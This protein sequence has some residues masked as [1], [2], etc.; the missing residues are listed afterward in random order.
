MLNWHGL[1]A[2]TSGLVAVLATLAFTVNSA[3]AEQPAS[4]SAWYA[5]YVRDSELVRL[6]NGRSLNLYC[7]GSGSPTVI[8]E[9][10][11]GGS[12]YSWW[13]VQEKIAK[14]TRVC[15]YDRAGSGK[16]P[17]GPFPR[18]TRAQVGDLEQLLLAAKV[19]PPYVLVGHSMGGYNVRV[20]ASR[21]MH[22]VVGL[23]FVDSATENQIPLLHS[24]VPASAENDKRSISRAQACADP[25][26][27]A[28]IA[29]QCTRS[30]PKDFP[31]ALAKIF[32]DTQGLSASQTFLSEVESFLAV[33]SQQV[34][35]EDRRFG[36]LPLIVLTRGALSSNLP[37]DQAELEWKH[38]N[39]THDKLAKLSKAG[40]HRVIADADHYIQLDKPDAVIAAVSEVVTLARK[41]GS[42]P[43]LDRH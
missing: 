1:A 43:T 29:E 38:W 9:S 22:D 5:A 33:D 24:A 25:A 26:R 16:S 35:A 39:Q 14:L 23:V 40:S 12:A 34:I 20:F 42:R 8:L 36:T 19:K 10:G 2:R 31:P 4:S 21:H 41:R 13:T 7:M 30:A 6:A 18:D 15:A 11:L 3:A 17:P 27:S 32:A 37:R 28:E